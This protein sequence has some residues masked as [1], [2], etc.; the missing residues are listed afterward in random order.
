MFET[1]RRLD[2]RAPSIRGF[3]VDAEGAMLGA[4]CVLVRRTPQGWR[5]LSPDEAA[6]LQDLLLPESEADWLFEQ[7]RRIA[8]AL[9]NG[10]T[11]LAQILGLRIPIAEFDDDTLQRLARA[12]PLIKANFNPAQPR[13]PAGSGRESGEWS[14]DGGHSLLVPA[15]AHRA[16]ARGGDP[17]EFFDTVYAP[18]HGLAQRLG[19]DETWLLGLAAHES[20]YREPHNRALNNPFGVTHGGGPNVATA[21]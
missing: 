5:C 21:R 6:A 8:K 17:N 2:S 4:D 10:E 19:I 12:A 3:A 9:G 20:W 14:D 18:I 13:V 15:A 16:P 1:M 11:A 7:C